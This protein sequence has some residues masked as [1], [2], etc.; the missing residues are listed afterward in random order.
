[1]DPREGGR[2]EHDDDFLDAEI[3][4]EMTTRRGELKHQTRSV[5]EE[6]IFQAYVAV[7]DQMMRVNFGACAQDNNGSVVQ[8]RMVTRRVMV[9]VREAEAI[10]MADVMKWMRY[11]GFR[12]VVFESD[13]QVVVRSIQGQDRDIT[14]F[15]DT[16]NLCRDLVEENP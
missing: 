12:E 11:T 14:E 1:M 9:L 4:D 5:R 6:R 2:D 10:A 13:A 15:G 3:L 7:F 8:F 16:I